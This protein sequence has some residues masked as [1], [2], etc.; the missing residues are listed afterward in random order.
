MPPDDP[1]DD[2]QRVP[3]KNAIEVSMST[4]KNKPFFQHIEDYQ[5]KSH[6]DEW[7][8]PDSEEPD[9]IVLSD[10]YHLEP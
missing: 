9:T 2:T 7:V 1:L 5:E 3:L 10:P 8:E 4:A 6:N